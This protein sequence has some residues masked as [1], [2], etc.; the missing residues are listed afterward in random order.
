[1]SGARNGDDDA[2]EK[3]IEG[4]ENFIEK[5]VARHTRTYLDTKSRDEYSVGLMAFNEAIDK[6]DPRH[7]R[8]FLSFAGEV[9]KKRIIDYYRKNKAQ[10]NCVPFYSFEC[11]E[12]LSFDHPQAGSFDPVGERVERESDMNSF[13]AELK[14]FKI[15]L[16]DLVKNTPKHRDSRLLSIKIARII[17]GDP[18]LLGGLHK[19]KVIPLKKLLGKIEV[20]P[21]TVERHRIYIITIC[22]VLA[23][24]LETLKSY[25]EQ[26]EKGGGNDGL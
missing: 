22:L 5:T 7:N 1:M 10:V 14:E 6:F 9:I 12:E 15:S 3:L 24:N 25:I 8:A 2:R 13:L 19:K 21:K 16:D 20:N 23:S 11:S 18:E 17:A 26:T 4:C